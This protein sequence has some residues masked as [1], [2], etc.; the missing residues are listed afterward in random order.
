VKGSSMEY[1]GIEFAVRARLG[2][3]RW[4]LTIL[5][6][7]PGPITL[8]FSISSEHA[9]RRL[10]P[11]TGSIS[12]WLANNPTPLPRTSAALRHLSGIEGIGAG[13]IAG[14]FAYSCWDLWRNWQGNR[15][16]GISARSHSSSRK[17]G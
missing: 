2:R 11:R 15:S 9:I 6:K 1:M 7:N 8:N 5:P 17:G 10:T 13:I 16:G 3:D 14:G 4:A 12:R